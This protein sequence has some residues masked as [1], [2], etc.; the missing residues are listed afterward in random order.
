MSKRA[1]IVSA[2][3]DL[4]PRIRSQYGKAELS[5]CI[6]MVHFE[7]GKFHKL[8]SD[9]EESK[10]EAAREKVELKKKAGRCCQQW[11]VKDG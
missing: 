11:A 3:N 4:E 5:R 9:Y 2:L 8:E 1:G 7:F 10:A 6:N